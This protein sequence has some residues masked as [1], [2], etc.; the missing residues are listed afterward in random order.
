[1][2]CDR[3]DEARVRQAGQALI[4]SVSLNFEKR[5]VHYACVKDLLAAN[6]ISGAGHSLVF[7]VFLTLTELFYMPCLCQDFVLNCVVMAVHQVP[8]I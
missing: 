2:K 7:E 4:P 3:L 1:M 5:W 6:T 8:C